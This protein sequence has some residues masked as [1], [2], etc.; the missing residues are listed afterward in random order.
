[1]KR[2]SSVVITGALLVVLGAGTA[3]AAPED[4]ANAVA[5]E[6]MSPYCE[7]V[8]LHD[9]PSDRAAELRDRITR[10]AES[11]W[12]KDMIIDKLSS[13][14]EFGPGILATP[15][16]SGSGLFAWLLPLAAVIGG[17]L[18]VL[19]LLTRWTKKDAPPPPPISDE[20]HQ[21]F[22]AEMAKFRTAE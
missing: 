6:I 13:P 10:W 22:E 7:G 2:L 9:C 11:G 15:P 16:R 5:N 4:V 12:T 18:L 21:R 14:S 1:M 19:L 20:D 3:S 17:A 8:T